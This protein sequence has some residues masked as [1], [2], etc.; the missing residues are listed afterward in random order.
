MTIFLVLNGMGVVF[1]LY[2]LA[3]F[4]KEGH[5]TGDKGPLYAREFGWRDRAEVFV[6]KKP[7]SN[8][9]QGALSVIPFHARNRELSGRQAGNTGGREGTQAP[10]RLVSAR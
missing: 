6:I 9:E 7:I 1:L 5:R 3:N 2:V 8:S 10:V 4:W